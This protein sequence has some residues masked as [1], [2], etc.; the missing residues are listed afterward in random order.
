MPHCASPDADAPPSRANAQGLGLPTRRAHTACHPACKR[1]GGKMPKTPKEPVRHNVAAFAIENRVDFLALSAAPDNS[2]WVKLQQSGI[3]DSSSHAPAPCRHY[4]FSKDIS[5]TQVHGG[6][7]RQEAY[8][9]EIVRHMKEAINHFIEDNEDGLSW[10]MSLDEI[11][12]SVP[13]VVE[14][15]STLI[16]LPLWEYVSEDNV[17]W[18]GEKGLNFR[19]VLASIIEDCIEEKGLI[20]NESR[21]K[22]LRKSIFVVN[23]ASSCAAYYSDDYSAKNPDH[24]IDLIYMKAHE[25]I[26]FGAFER[27]LWFPSRPHPEYGHIYP[28][29]HERDFRSNFSGSCHFHG[30]CLEGVVSMSSF[31]ERA[32]LARKGLWPLQ[33][34]GDE[35]TKIERKHHR[36]D[37]IKSEMFDKLF[38]VGEAA[39]DLHGGVELLAH[40]VSQAIHHILLSPISPN[41]IYIGGRF[42]KK[43]IVEAI[44]ENLGVMFN[45]YP[46]REGFSREA[47][48]AMI[49][50]APTIPDIEGTPDLIK[51]RR[52]LELLGATVIALSRAPYGNT[53]RPHPD[54]ISIGERQNRRSK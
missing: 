44:V 16:Q 2:G 12:I 23:D 53:S 38:G 33:E 27:D 8:Y 45:G 46:A 10:L 4:V 28:N 21:S 43:L 36:D 24:R 37:K 32:K 52:K 15:G 54:V 26:N 39:P 5:P 29:P 7:P 1:P 3:F 25:G 20:W 34:W 41:K 19:E 18:R 11:A 30:C 48:F 47:L 9:E 6:K 49:E 13:G 31:L 14:N 51:G 42:G 40:Y 50:A 22:K 17:M 35:L